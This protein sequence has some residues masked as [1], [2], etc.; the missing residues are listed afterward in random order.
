[1]SDKGSPLTTSFEDTKVWNDA[2]DLAVKVYDLTKTFPDSERF[3]LIS[4]LNR[5]SVS[6]ST[7]FAEGFGRT[8]KN[9]KKHFY[10][11]AYGS[12]LEVKSL[13]YLSKRLGLVDDIEDLDIGIR[14]IQ[15]QL[16]AIRK[17]LSQ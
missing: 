16:N 3:G 11:I 7:N 1:V 8:S 12:L 17:S 5:A 2:V 4:Q 14:D 9:D 13:L 6:V 15:I 10:V